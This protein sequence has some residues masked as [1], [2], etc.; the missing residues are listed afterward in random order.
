MT[1][2][3]GGFRNLNSSSF[4]MLYKSLVRPRLEFCSPVWGSLSAALSDSVESVQR[5]ATWLVPELRHLSYSERLRQ[6]GLPTLAYR[7]FRADLLAA[8]SML[9]SADPVGSRVLSRRPQNVTRGHSLMLEKLRRKTKIGRRFFSSRVLQHWNALPEECISAPSLNDFKSVLNRRFLDFPLK[10]D[11]RHGRPCRIWY[12]FIIFSD[13]CLCLPFDSIILF[14]SYCFYFS[15]YTG[16][17]FSSCFL[18]ALI[19]FIV[20][21]IFCLLFI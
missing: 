20:I 21:V 14:S 9:R 4:L 18:F 15:F 1:I 2:F 16:S 5:R 3:P 6:I 13:S 19:S 10:F 17:L 11:W 12:Y 7:R 8:R